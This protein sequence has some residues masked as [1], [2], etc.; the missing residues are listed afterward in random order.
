MIVRLVTVT[1]F[2]LTLIV[3]ILYARG[4]RLD[5]Q[6]TQITPRGIMAVTSSPKSAKIIVDGVLKGVTDSTIYLPPGTFVV[7]V[8]KDGY[9]PW[10]KTVKV[11]G[12]IVQS[13]DATLY[14]VNASLTPL[15]N[16]GVEHAEVFGIDA[17]KIL[18]F[19]SVSQGNEI[20]IEPSPTP[21]IAE[22]NTPGIFIY[23]PRIQAVSI[24]PTLVQIARY[25]DIIGYIRPSDTAVI[26]SPDFDQ[27]ILFVG[28]GEDSGTQ[29]SPT[30]QYDTV[31][32]IPSTFSHAYLLNTNEMNTSL[33][34]VTDSVSALTDAW[35]L[36]KQSTIASVLDGYHDTV[37][38]F[39][40]SNVRII[41]ISAD[42]TRI[43]YEATASATLKP[44]L[45]KPL[46]GANQT[47]Q[48]R[49]VN[50]AY[51][52]VYDVREDRNYQILDSNDSDQ[53]HALPLFHPNSKNIILDERNAIGVVDYDGLNR[54]K[55]Y[56]GPY[57]KQF[58][59]ITADG[60]VLILTKFNQGDVSGYDLYSLGIR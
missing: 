55:L 52:Y 18:L 7:R 60:R 20:N 16:I 31:Y 10:S 48:V 39:L 42:R 36:I 56:S 34:D 41:D 26:F 24:F 49:T 59:S 32:S 17:K 45:K 1:L 27:L 23:D 2:L 6:N 44:V 22:E 47:E 5:V 35:S 15:T 43:L 51:M 21:P 8:V 54:Q 19:S 40:T 50:P 25:S 9:L 12:E 37:R 11:Q 53:Q 46:I 33:L 58:F 3:L 4:Y 28:I 29:T 57:D 13:V 14:P 30:S 38:Q